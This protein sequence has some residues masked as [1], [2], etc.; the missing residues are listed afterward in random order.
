MKKSIALLFTTIALVSSLATTPLAKAETDTFSAAE[1]VLAARTYY[2]LDDKGQDLS[3]GN[4]QESKISFSEMSV[5]K[6]DVQL[7][8]EIAYS[9]DERVPFSLSGTLGKAEKTDDLIIGDLVDNSGNFEVIHFGLDRSP[10]KSIVIDQKKRGNKP[11]L[12][13]YLLKQGT[14][15]LTVL[16]VDVPKSIKYK[17]LFDNVKSFKQAEYSDQ[18]WYHKIFKPTEAKELGANEARL[19]SEEDDVVIASLQN[20]SETRYY[21]Y[22]YNIS[23]CS[24]YEDFYVKHYLEGPK[25]ITT[26][27][28]F[29]SKMYVTHEETWSLDCDSMNSDE[30]GMHIGYYDPTIIQAYTEP[31]DVLRYIQWD[32]T[33]YEEDDLNIVARWDV[34]FPY[35]TL[36]FTGTWEFAERH[37][38]NTMKVFDN[39]G[40]KKV[41]QAAVDFDEKEQQ[42]IDEDDSFDVIFSVGYYNQ[43]GNKN[44]RVKWDYTISNDLDYT[45]TDEKSERL[46]LDYD[47][48]N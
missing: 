5:S 35:T 31:G 14:R 33:Y 9:N 7:T 47:S 3:A 28:E 13:L 12:K 17:E 20:D 38:S 39:S 43:S 11:I 44:F 19:V 34:A 26:S 1:E 21:Q 6:S 29:T 32:G 30:T 27:D 18:F 46:S 24:I 48:G 25:E 4:H 36:G 22:S 40:E 41:R 16:E 8:G 15:D 23:G 45:W 42:L 37:E 2:N 10:D